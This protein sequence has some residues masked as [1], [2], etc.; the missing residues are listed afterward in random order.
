MEHWSDLFNE[1]MFEFVNTFARKEGSL[2]K[3]DIPPYNGDCVLGIL[4]TEQAERQLI[5]E[6][7][8]MKQ[9]HEKHNMG[10]VC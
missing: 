10:I 1:Q 7:W 3:H 8:L 5:W 9:L 2:E 4:L 6:L